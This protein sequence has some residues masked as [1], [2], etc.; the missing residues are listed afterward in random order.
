MSTS[1]LPV[2]LHRRLLEH[3]GSRHLGTTDDRPP[4]RLQVEGVVNGDVVT[5]N[6]HGDLSDAALSLLQSVL[7][8]L[9]QL[10]P[11][12]VIVDLSRVRTAEVGAL[13][14]IAKS[15]DTVPEFQL[16]SPNVATHAL[17]IGLGCA[18]IVVQ[19]LF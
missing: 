19:Q 4:E 9:V 7:D 17:L 11:R 15:R 14:L 8:G 13:R 3:V 10:E 18:D 1:F 6:L 16:R 5:L 2:P 12:R